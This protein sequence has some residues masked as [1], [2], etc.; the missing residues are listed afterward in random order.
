[1]ERL[2]ELLCLLGTAVQAHVVGKRRGV[3][4]ERLAEISGVTESDTIYSIDKFSEEA[5][6]SWFSASWPI[7]LPVEVIVEGW[8]ELAPVV[9]PKSAR[10][11]DTKYVVIIDP[12]DGT[13]ELMYDKR[14]AWVLAGVAP[15]KFGK[16][17]VCDIEVAMMTELPV[18]KQILADQVSGFRGCGAKGIVSVRR[19]LETNEV[20]S[21]QLTPSSSKTVEHGVATFVKVFPEAKE[22]ISRIETEL[23]KRL[24][25]FGESKSPVVFDDQYISTGG[26]M[27]GLLCGHYR[28]Y[29]DIR[30]HALETLGLDHTLT[31]HPYDVAAGLLLQ[32][33]GCIYESPFGMQV[34]ARLDTVSPVSWVGYANAH[35]ADSI[36]PPLEQLMKRYFGGAGDCQT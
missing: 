1:M 11:E 13:R 16:T 34:D 15:Q 18:T 31:C 35:L 7:D 30:P 14:S 3:D 25:L 8:E 10:V 26:Q 17:R 20:F 33:A 27:Y 32:E 28:F 22:L 6:F 21:I 29:G 5:L 36:R 4:R 2:R 24:G 23:W 19:N 9:F 12:I